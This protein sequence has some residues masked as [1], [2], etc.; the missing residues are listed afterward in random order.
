[1]RNVDLRR[2]GSSTPEQERALRAAATMAESVAAPMIRV[3]SP[4]R[5]H[6]FADEFGAQTLRRR[7][8]AALLGSP[9]LRPLCEP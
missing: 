4:Q 5:P 3:G 9:S 2:V 1:V 6:Q 8:C 7:I